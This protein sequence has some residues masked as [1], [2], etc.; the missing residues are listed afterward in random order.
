[1]GTSY[2]EPLEFSVGVALDL[3]EPKIKEAS[4]DTS[5]NPLDAQT[6]LTALVDY[7]GMQ[8][9]DEIT[10][11]WAAAE[12]APADGSHTTQPWPVTTVGLQQIP[13]LQTLV[14][15]NL[16]KPVTVSY[17]V[18]RGDRET[19]PSPPH[20]LTVLPLPVSALEKSSITEAPNNGEGPE[21]DITAL[22][23][24]ASVRTNIWPLGAF[25]Q[26]VRLE[27]Q[28]QKA[29]GTPHDIV[30]MSEDKNA[31]HQAWLNQGYHTVNA[32]YSY[33]KELAHDSELKVVFKASLD[34]VNVV[35]FPI[36]A[37]TVLALD[38]SAP[39]I[40]E[41]PNDTSLNPLN[42]QTGLTALVDYLGMMVGDKI[43]VTWT[44]AEGTPEGGSQTAEPWPV[45][46]VGPQQVPLL[47][48][49]VA[50]NLEKSVTVS[51]IVI[52]GDN[53]PVPSPPRTLA[54]SQLPQS[55]LEKSWITEAPNNGE[56]P[57]LDITAL[58]NGASIRTNIWPL[59]AVGQPVGLELQG[60]KTDGT[61]HNS[62][63]LTIDKNTV[64]Q[65][66]L[67]QGYYT[68]TAPYSYF[69]DLA[70]DSELKVVL[71]AS[72]DTINVVIFP[73]RVY[74]ISTKQFGVPSFTNPLYTIAPAGRLKPIELLL[75]TSSDAPIPGGHLSLTLPADFTY[76][77]GGS[78]QR[79]F[80]TDAV[81]RVSISDVKGTNVPGPYTLSVSSGAQVDTANVTITSLGPV[82]S[83]AVGGGSDGIAV[84]PDGTRAYVSNSG[85]HTVS[86]IDT[87]T[88]LVLKHI[89]VGNGPRW[90]AVSQDGTRAYVCNYDP[91]T[92]SV[93]DTATN[94]VLKNIKCGTYTRGIAFS[95]DG[96]LAYVSNFG[97]HTVS[98][99]D[100]ATDQVLRNIS[101]GKGP[102]GIA[103]SPNGT[104]IYVS[105]YDNGTVSVIDATT[106]QI[107]VSI[108]VGSRPCGILIN[109]AGTRIYVSNHASQ[110]VSVIDTETDQ[111]LTHIPVGKLPYWLAASPD[112]KRIFVSNYDSHTVSVID[113]T[114]NEVS[115]TISGGS[116]PYGIA[117]SADGTRIYVG[118][119][120]IS[121]ISVIAV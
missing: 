115:E 12:G 15:F 44:G 100:T 113:T 114:T 22:V 95:P 92:V 112:G 88:N 47:K 96:T 107:L 40:E 10:V 35:T 48:S 78:G 118:N 23:N 6:S 53:D 39:R 31:V 94:Q 17:V 87:A 24:G 25:G 54:V 111:V 3:K 20:T 43:I 64:D 79:E 8:V 2:A 80:V 121:R 73:V 108:P 106:N 33:L 82:G 28:G 116:N 90:V 14:A 57:E 5:L 21:L 77:D 42:T 101:T 59:G 13:L 66:W 1:G 72:L 38:L 46:T 65:A 68:V 51:Y 30:L 76:A 19:V 75:S 109:E 93:I 86:V 7:V 97:S 105:N 18:I 56:G 37:Y 120:T 41:A 71:K 52:R 117:I 69:K 36:R 70:H 4:N 63:L 119:H 45:T 62:V 16:D 89:R 9:G 74:S 98:V 91:G 49:V 110:T 27:L 81:G 11:T 84:S 55:A 50:F 83:I 104:R 67:D 32:P 26:P 29:D 60:E 34:T 61:Q 85:S 103:I 99:I 58:V 102:Y